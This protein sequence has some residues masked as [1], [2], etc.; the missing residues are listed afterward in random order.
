MPLRFTLRQLEYLVAVG[1][2]GSIAQASARVNVSSPSISAAIAQLEAEF[3][4]PLFVRR[5]AHGLSLTQGGR[6]F[7]SLARKVLAEAATLSDLAQEITGTVGGP[8]AIGCLQ[9]FAQVVLPQLRRSFEAAWPAVSVSQTE[10]DQAGLISALRRA[11]IDVALTYDL[12]VPPD[13]EFYPLVELP[14]HAL[15]PPDHP[16]AGRAA[17]SVEDLA[18]YPMV[19]LDLPLSS[20]YF[21]SFFAERGLRPLD[22]GQ[23]LWLFHRQPAPRVR[24][25][26]GRAAAGLRA[27]RRRPAPDDDG[28]DDE[29]R[30]LGRPGGQRPAAPRPR[31]GDGRDDRGAAPGP[32][33]HGPGLG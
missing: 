28:P 17:V 25:R 2:C 24:L 5:H 30:G 16:L 26:P 7:V 23:R 1:E 14:P 18:P 29:C 9:T 22:G 20:E 4:L 31:A 6:Q 3:G 33:R 15:M 32:A 27:A 13:M 8:L 21:L 10:T 11:E 12:Q 19:L